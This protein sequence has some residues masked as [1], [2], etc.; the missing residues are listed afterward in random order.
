MI[1][2]GPYRENSLELIELPNMNLILA[3]LTIIGISVA[4]SSE[5]APLTSEMVG[6]ILIVNT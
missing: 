1:L 2:T 5:Q 4:L 3:K 6:L